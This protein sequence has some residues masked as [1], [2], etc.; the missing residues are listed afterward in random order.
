MKKILF[1]GL[2]LMCM[3]AATLT[4]PRIEFEAPDA[5]PEGVA[6]DSVGK[7]YYVSS[8]RLGSIGKVSPDGRYSVFYTD[9]TLK[10]SYGLKISPDNKKLYACIGDA[11][12]SKFKTPETDKKMARLIAVDL[13]TGKKI[14]DVD[15]SKL[16]PGKHFS[17]DLTFDKAG[18]AYITDSF[19]NAIYK[20]TPDGKASVFAT[21]EL[22]KSEGVSLNGIVAHPSGFLIVANG[23]TGSLLKVDI[24]SPTNV[25]KI[26]LDQFFMNA[27]GLLLD[28]KDLI[29]VQ[30][31][32]VNKIYRFETAD[33]WASAKVKAATHPDDHYT[34]PSTATR[35]NK[36]IWVMNAKFNELA[37]STNVPSKKF[38]IQKAIFKAVP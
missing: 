22:F 36:E 25:Q 11:N 29:L 7:N 34:F 21:H 10:S 16:I 19:A 14:T 6:Y 1:A 35:A 24:K 4:T 17:N 28:G 37:D 20:V 30:N 38:N 32:S 15:L 9:N 8:A 12:Y 27:D 26:K 2:V 3:A 13:K 31:G 5:Y 23:G 33:N 18:N